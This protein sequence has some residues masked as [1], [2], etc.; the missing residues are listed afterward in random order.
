MRLTC[1]L[2]SGLLACGASAAMAQVGESIHLEVLESVEIQGFEVLSTAGRLNPLPAV[3][4]WFN[5]GRSFFLSNTDHQITVG[6]LGPGVALTAGSS[7]DTGIEYGGLV[8]GEDLAMAFGFGGA[9]P[10]EGDPG[11]IRVCV[12]PCLPEPA[13]SQLAAWGAVFLVGWCRRARHRANVS[14]VELCRKRW[15]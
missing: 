3:P 6:T 5:P 1:L 9:L 10:V 2:V 4:D 8:A 12:G 13:S 15:S 7:L 11:A 14:S